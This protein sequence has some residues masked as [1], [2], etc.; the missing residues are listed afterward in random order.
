MSWVDY[1]L[2]LICLSWAGVGIYRWYAVSK[3]MLDAPNDRSSHMEPKPRGGGIIFV[4]G[5]ALLAVTLYYYQLI[6]LEEVLLFTPA[7]AIG[8]LGTLD[9][10]K[11]LSA[12]FR[13][14]VHFLA[15]STLLFLLKEGGYLVQNFLDLPLP[16][17]FMVLVVGI[18]W[19]TNL[20]NFMDGTD[21]LAATEALFCLGLGGYFIFAAEGFAFSTL[22][23]GIMAMVIGF[24]IWNW[25]T[26]KIFMGDSGSG[27]LGFLI[28]TFALI[29]HKQ[30]NI[31][32]Y[33][34]L[35]M[36]SL[37]WF[38]ATVTLIR[39]IIAKEKWYKPHRKHAYQRMVQS[40]WS[41]TKVLLSSIVINTV[42]AGLSYWAFHKPQLNEILLLVAIAFLA[43]VYVLVELAKP[44]Y[45]DYHMDVTKVEDLT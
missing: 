34:W 23:W 20:Y 8:L 43:A 35:I 9:D 37:F 1:F 4:F 12:S 6:A 7:V 39:R 45:H 22:G 44:M 13:F 31:S 30:F 32:I 28:A 29:G 5:S 16:L 17:C 26:A 25:P 10:F 11:G 33:V 38:D 19:F 42:L 24:L 3:G 15:A 2:L 27:F 36:S 40:G 21:G 14:I 18:V 41:H